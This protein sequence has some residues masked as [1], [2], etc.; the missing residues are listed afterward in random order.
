MECEVDSGF[1]LDHLTRSCVEDCPSGTFSDDEECLVCGAKCAECEDDPD[2]CS[3]CLP[4]LKMHEEECVTACPSH[5]YLNEENECH[6]CADECAECIG[7]LNTDCSRCPPHH[8]I[9]LGTCQAC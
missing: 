4:G 2:L 8:I 6:P 9:N 7:P 5:T 3:S 1:K